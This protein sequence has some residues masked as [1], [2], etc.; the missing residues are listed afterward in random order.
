MM[1]E[2][3]NL[4]DIKQQEAYDFD[5]KEAMSYSPQE[6]QEELNL[7]NREISRAEELSPPTPNLPPLSQMIFSN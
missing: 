1:G 7:L 6:A 4:L 2:I 3:N 5:L